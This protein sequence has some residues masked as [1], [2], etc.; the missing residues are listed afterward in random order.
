[1]DL[2]QQ[3]WQHFDLFL[4]VAARTAAVFFV[5][6]PFAA[7]QIPGQ[8]RV[9]FGLLFALVLLPVVPLPPALPATLLPWLA[10]AVRETFVGLA[11]GWTASLVFAGVQ[12]G[13]QL[14]DTELGF[15]IVNVLDPQTG[16]QLPLVGN[17]QYLL[18]LLV[19][20]VTNGH[21]L[22]LLALAKS[23]TAVPVGAAV[24]RPS[25]ADTVTALTGGVFLTAF[26]LAAPVLGAGF[27]TS[28]ALGVM[29]RAM[30][31]MNVFM[32]GM[33]LKL[34][35][36]LVVLTAGMPLYLVTLN[37]VLDGLYASLAQILQAVHP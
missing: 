15:G 31:Q 16:Q 19:L 4:L 17:F 23:F 28:V 34:V 24:L 10:W 3:L 26:K 5:A 12:L 35:A 2:Y 29:S 25:L 1:M 7:R 18:A 30:P 22:M 21:H 13:G 32:V 36:G 14:L 11:I 27:V 8:W 20:L 9:A 37:R 6:P 33:P